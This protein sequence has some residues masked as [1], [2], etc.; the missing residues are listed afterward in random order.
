MRLFDAHCDTLS[1]GLQEV[2][3]FAAGAGFTKEPLPQVSELP[4][5][6]QSDATIDHEGSFDPHCRVFAIWGPPGMGFE[7]VFKPLYA[8]YL[9]QVLPLAPRLTPLL[10]V[11]GAHVLD[12]SLERLQEAATCGLKLLNL[13]WNNANILS[14]S[15]AEEPERGL[16]DQGRAY[17]QA[18]EQL[19]VYVDVSHLSD[20]GFWDLVAMA[21]KPIVASHSNSR[22][23]H[24]HVRNLTDEQFVAIARSGGV[25]GI[26]LHTDFV[27][28]RDIPAL[29]GHITH[30]LA[31]EGGEQALGIGTDYD[32]G[33]EAIEGLE[34][35]GG[36]LKLH[37]TLLDSGL[38]EDLVDA[39]F[40]RNWAR[41]LG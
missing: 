12:C 19:G 22:A 7:T 26:N 38:K 27:G 16:S 20:A 24:P 4:I 34:K 11:E 15:C 6:V 30:F 3:D 31:L 8:K 35:V 29:L 10:S 14:G 25:V 33:I 40:Y 41:L 37:E 23:I 39:I 5:F 1:L 21:N 36:L 32:G 9:E 2:F 17:V 13:V 28:G 18:C